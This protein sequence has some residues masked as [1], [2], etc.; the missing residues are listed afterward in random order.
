MGA[1]QAVKQL[2]RSPV[3]RVIICYYYIN[4]VILLRV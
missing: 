4:H 1:L 3:K 2:N